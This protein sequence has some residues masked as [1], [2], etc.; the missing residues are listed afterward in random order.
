[1]N[2]EQQ[3]PTHFVESVRTVSAPGAAIKVQQLTLTVEGRAALS[4]KAQ[5][6]APEQRSPAT[7]G[8]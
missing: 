6:P 7:A 1:M 5:P 2:Q 3:T 4:G 8:R